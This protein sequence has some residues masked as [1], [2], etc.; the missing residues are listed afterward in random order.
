VGGSVRESRRGG[1]D[2]SLFG[3]GGG[4]FAF[5]RPESYCWWK[6][7]KRFH[8][9]ELSKEEGTAGILHRKKES[10]EGGDKRHAW[11]EKGEKKMP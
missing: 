4:I 7:T 8:L 10:Y 2:P 5:C 3:E 1:E 6:G 11:V 9:C